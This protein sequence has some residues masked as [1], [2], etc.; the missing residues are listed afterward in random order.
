[1]TLEQVNEM[2]QR[3]VNSTSFVDF[4]LQLSRSLVQMAAM[5]TNDPNHYLDPK[6]AAV[7]SDEQAQVF[8]DTAQDQ[9]I[10]MA[11]GMAAVSVMMKGD[12]SEKVELPLL[13]QRLA[14]F[15]QT[16]EL[17]APVMHRTAVRVELDAGGQLN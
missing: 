13:L 2:L 12:D 16:L 4:A 14:M 17:L 15:N 3:A 10:I 9:M 11:S 8:A 1:M 5:T 7:L 6:M